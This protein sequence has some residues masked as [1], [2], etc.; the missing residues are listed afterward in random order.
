M[1]DLVER[2]NGAYS[3]IFERS[4]A[5]EAA[6]E[7]EQ[8]RAKLNTPVASQVISIDLPSGSTVS[9]IVNAPGDPAWVELKAL[10]TERD[11]LKKLLVQIHDRIAFK[12]TLLGDDPLQIA[13][14]KAIK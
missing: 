14:E 7:I 12:Q 4:L 9:F 2:L 3:T 13:I 5:R 11:A 1:N 8:L 6:V 10:I